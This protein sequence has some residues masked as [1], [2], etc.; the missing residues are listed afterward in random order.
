MAEEL[1]L[2]EHVEYVIDKVARLPIVIEWR[3]QIEKDT[4]LRALLFSDE[5]QGLETVEE[6]VRFDRN[7]NIH[8]EAYSE[9]MNALTLF[10]SYIRAEESHKQIHVDKSYFLCHGSVLMDFL[11]IVYKARMCGVLG[12]QYCPEDYF[13]HTCLKETEVPMFHF[14]KALF[15]DNAALHHYGMF[16]TS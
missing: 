15:L 12:D 8:I 13:E 10:D 14:I 16:L 2:N 5:P 1:P 3:E 4:D 9:I 7:D 6:T 11:V